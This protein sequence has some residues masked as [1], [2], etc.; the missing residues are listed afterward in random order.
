MTTD[1]TNALQQADYVVSVLPSTPATRDLLSNGV[2]QVASRA[3][4]GKSPVFINVGRGDVVSEDC[5]IQALDQ[6][7]LSA[8]ILDVFPVEPLP[9]G[10]PLWTRSDVVISPHVSGITRASDVPAVF[11]DNYQRYCQEGGGPGKLQFIVD[12]EKGY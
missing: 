11:L 5:L 12:W 9:A 6:Q 1:L 10:S 7:Y 8:A 2:L 4:G 3:H